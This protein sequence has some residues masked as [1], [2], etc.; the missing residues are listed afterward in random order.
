MYQAEV[1]TDD[2][3]TKHYIG[4]TEHLFKTRHNVH[5]QSLRNQKYQHS[6]ALSKHIWELKNR[7]KSY[8]INWSIV[9]RA[10]PY[11]AGVISCSLCTQEKLCIINADK[12]TLLN[13]RSELISKCRHENK[14]YACNYS[15]YLYIS[16]NF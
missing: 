15:P 7:G 9:K 8:E 4:M 1:K 13:K 14:F 11:K 2:D 16:Y 3:Q 6:T 12:E 5:K 10:K